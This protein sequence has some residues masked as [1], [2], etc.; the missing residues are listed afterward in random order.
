MV[1]QNHKNGEL[2][3]SQRQALIKLIEKRI[4]ITN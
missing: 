3:I 4:R 2:R 1:Q